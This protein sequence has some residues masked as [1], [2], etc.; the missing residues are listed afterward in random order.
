MAWVLIKTG[1]PGGNFSDHQ[2]WQLDEASDI[3]T[4]PAEAVNASPGSKAWTGDFAH[5]WNKANDG[6]WIDIMA[7]E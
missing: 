1:E 6:T 7:G 5:I 3:N 2:E 4:V